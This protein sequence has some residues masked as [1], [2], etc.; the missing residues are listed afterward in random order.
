MIYGNVATLVSSSAAAVGNAWASVAA[1]AGKKYQIL[2]FN[3][4]ASTIA[5][6]VYVRFGTSPVIRM[7]STSGSAVSEWYGELGP[8]SAANQG[9]AVYAHNGA[10]KYCWAN[11]LYRVVF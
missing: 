10:A 9:V 11:L 5:C 2:G 4:G 7:E 8:V 3:A 1:A 6:H